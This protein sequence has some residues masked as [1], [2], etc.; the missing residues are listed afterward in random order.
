M[1]RGLRSRKFFNNFTF[2]E[3]K[4]VAAFDLIFILFIQN[5]FISFPDSLH[6]CLRAL[7]YIDILFLFFWQFFLAFCIKEINLVILLRRTIIE[8]F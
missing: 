7:I 3:P 2:L 4:E 5:K 6:L 1:S 8:T